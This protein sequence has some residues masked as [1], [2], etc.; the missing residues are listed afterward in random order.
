MVVLKFAE[1]V[2]FCHGVCSVYGE[3]RGNVLEFSVVID[4]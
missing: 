4:I 1:V 3:V 2:A